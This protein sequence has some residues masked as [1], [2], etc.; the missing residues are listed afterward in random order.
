MRIMSQNSKW[1]PSWKLEVVVMNRINYNKITRAYY[2]YIWSVHKFNM[3]INTKKS[4]ENTIPSN[5]WTLLKA[6]VAIRILFL[7]LGSYSFDYTCKYMLLI[8]LILKG[9]FLILLHLYIYNIQILTIMYSQML[10]GL[11]VCMT[12]LKY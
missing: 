9:L 1:K 3:I 8:R 2:N 6:A 11:F 12:Y 10:L 7:I 4:S 5:I